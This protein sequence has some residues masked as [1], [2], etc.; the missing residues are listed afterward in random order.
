SISP[1]AV[2]EDEAVERFAVAAGHVQLI[3]HGGAGPRAFAVGAGSLPEGPRDQRVGAFGGRLGSARG[4]IALGRQLLD[5]DLAELGDRLRTDLLERE[6][7]ECEE[8][9]LVRMIRGC[10][11]VHLDDDMIAL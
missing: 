3:R 11:T 1:D 8:P 9:L 4:R 7:T 5:F 2:V 10:G 6:M